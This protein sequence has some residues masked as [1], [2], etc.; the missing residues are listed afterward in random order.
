MGKF[1][2]SLESVQ[3]FKD[4]NLNTIKL[5]YAAAENAVADQKLNI[6]CLKEE[7]SE[8][9][10]ALKLKKESGL[11][12]LEYQSLQSHLM[13]IQEHIEDEI[14]KLGELERKASLVRHKMIQAKVESAS[15]ESIRDQRLEEFNADEKKKED[16]FIEEFV[17][18][19]RLR[20]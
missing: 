15:I 17:S 18:N 9:K 19:K 3:R 14:M 12:V 4:Q 2:F 8:Y 5:E 7:Y 10:A 13:F 16:A 20:S 11:S 6:S 1:K